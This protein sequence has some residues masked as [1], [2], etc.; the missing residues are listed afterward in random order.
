MNYVQAP[1]V[2]PAPFPPPI[3]IGENII[4]ENNIQKD[5][6]IHEENIIIDDLELDGV[7]QNNNVTI[8]NEI[9]VNNYFVQL[10]K[11]SQCKNCFNPP[12]F[13][14]NCYIGR[15]ERLKTPLF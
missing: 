11:S 7:I 1:P 6:I 12:G 14:C 2:S 8:D 10:P 9:F 13:D 15:A 3:A 4:Y 5:N